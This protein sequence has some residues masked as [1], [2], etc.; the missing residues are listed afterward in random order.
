MLIVYTIFAV[1]GG[2]V[3]VCQLVLNLIGL[4]GEHFDFMGELGLGDHGVDLGDHHADLGG[5]GIEGHD[6]SWFFGMLSFRSLVAAVAFFGLGGLAG[7][8]ASLPE[9]FSFVLA[10]AAG[11]VAMI[12]V[13]WMLRFF[14][15]LHDEG[16]VYIEN[17]VGQTGTVYLSIPGHNT[18][19][20]KVT[21]SVQDRSMEF[22]AVTSHDALPSGS[23]VVV[24]GIVSPDTVKVEP[25]NE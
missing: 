15:S 8:S 17:A 1:V 14:Y 10:L 13:A 19:T 16:N 9:Y 12:A 22:L 18:G 25:L 24:I 2:V 5:H 23:A 6:A 20:G 21:V 11:A 7:L 4:G 3:L